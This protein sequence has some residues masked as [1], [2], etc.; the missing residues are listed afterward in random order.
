MAISIANN[1]SGGFLIT[2]DLVKPVVYLDHWAIRLFSQ[3]LDLQDRFISALHSSKGT[4]LFSTANLM[5]FTA[6]TDLSQAAAAE[7]LLERANPSVHFSDLS[8]DPGYFIESRE[9]FHPD[10]PAKDWLLRDLAERA[11]IKNGLFNTHRF[12]QD[13]IRNRDLLLPLFTDLKESIANA[14]MELTLDAKKNE[15][16]KKFYPN[17]AAPLCSTIFSELL[18]EPHLDQK[19]IFSDNDAMDFVHAAPAIV[20]CEY[21]LLDSG[22]CHKIARAVARMRKAGVEEPIAQCFSNKSVN[23][24]LNNL[25]S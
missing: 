5:E 24:F 11:K 8:L 19:Y 23:E 22:W 25:S 2:Q 14:V 15:S 4:W 10:A 16:A 13:A 21:V 12:I 6:M 1:R 3:D 9:Y 7:K 17:S 18:R 20:A